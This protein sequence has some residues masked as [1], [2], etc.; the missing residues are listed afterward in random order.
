M[1]ARIIA[2]LLLFFSVDAFS[3]GILRTVDL[4]RYCGQAG[5][6]RQTLIYLDQSV[7][8]RK[9]QNWY[10]DILNKT[11]Y[12][13]GERIQIININDGG[14]TVELIWDTCYPSYT[15]DTYMKL[16][17][18]QGFKAVFTGGVDETLENDKKVFSNR[19]NQALAFPLKSTRHEY[20]PKYGEEFPRKKL[21]EAFYYDSKRMDLKSGIPRIIVFSDMIENSDLVSSNEKDFDG[22]KKSES[23]SKRFPV[24]YNLSSFYVYGINYTNSNTQLNENIERFWRDYMLKSGAEIAH[25]GSQLVLPKPEG[26]IK[27]NSFKGTMKQSDGRELLVKVR[28]SYLPTG[29]LIHSWF[30]LGDYYMPIEGSYSCSGQNCQLD[31]RIKESAFDG[32]RRG[33][34]VNLT[35]TM[36]NLTGVVGAR[37]ET[38]VDS[39]G[40]IYQFKL[41]VQKET[42]SG[43]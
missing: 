1:N 2:I 7:I 35:G 43:I 36:E 5:I 34:I 26:L 38:V 37:D 6:E 13:P 41:S 40:N 18:N 22:V 21:V 32:F 30:V 4:K 24:Y 11:H 12:F 17:D 10:K 33:D 16:K 20:A 8:A 23:A 14:S 9:D 27:T 19:L 28:L 31:S 29:K 15:E 42:V 25:Y 3:E 39:K